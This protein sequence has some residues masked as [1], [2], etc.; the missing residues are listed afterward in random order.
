M[1]A[2]DLCSEESELLSFKGIPIHSKLARYSQVSKMN[3]NFDIL[4]YRMSIVPG[5]TKE[6]DKILK[7]NIH[8]H[9]IPQR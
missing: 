4:S 7:N 6:V 3:S 8:P 5:A 9:H 2:K 1:K